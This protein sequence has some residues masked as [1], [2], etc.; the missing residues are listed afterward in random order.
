MPRAIPSVGALSAE[1]V[2]ERLARRRASVD[3]L[4]IAEARR[5]G[6]SAAE[7]AL[8][9]PR[10]IS[11]ALTAQLSLYRHT[12]NFCAT[13]RDSHSASACLRVQVL[14]PKIN[15]FHFSENHAFL[16][17][18]RANTRGVSR[19]SRTW[20]G[21]RWTRMWLLTSATEADGEVVW[22]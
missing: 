4:F 10:Q 15:L 3:G 2:E 18:L 5:S 22:S 17:S 16:L 14:R 13:I 6:T 11:F 19:S 20:C 1:Y 9:T 7:K 21:M 12:R 8:C